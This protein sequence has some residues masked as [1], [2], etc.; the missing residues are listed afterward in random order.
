MTTTTTTTNSLLKPHQSGFTKRHS[1][2][3][4]FTSMYKKLVSAI[5]HQQVS[6]TFWG[7][8]VE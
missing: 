3:T 5:S 1:T 8:S 7:G 6:Y 4:L 2:E